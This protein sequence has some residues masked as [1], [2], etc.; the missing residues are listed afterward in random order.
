VNDAA[1]T[2]A[3]RV[4]IDDLGVDYLDPVRRG[5]EHVE[6]FTRFPA[7]SRV[8][9]KPNLTYPIY[10]PGVM[11]SIECLSAVV[12]LLVDRG[13]R[14]TIG[15]ADSGGYNRFSMDEVFDATGI[16]TLAT[17]QGVEILNLSFTEPVVF[18]VRCGLRRLR[19]P[20]PR[21]LLEGFDAFV[22]LPVPKIHMNTLVSLSIKN[23]W[24]CI[25]DP[26]QR[27]RLHPYFSRVIFEVCSRLPPAFAIVDG[28]WGLDRSGPLLGDPVRLDWLMVSDDL[29]A[30]DRTVCRLMG[31]EE[32]K[33]SHL[34]SF[35][36]RGWWG[37]LGAVRVNR[38]LAP[39]ARGTFHLRR[40]WTD[41][42]GLACF[43]SAALAWVGYHSPIAGLLHRLLY[44]FRNPFYD[45]EYESRK[46]AQKRSDD[47]GAQN[48]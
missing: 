20:V 47:S 17:E 38:D 44:V 22:S 45:Y 24:G 15:E 13:Y 21:V 41:L 36:E 31:I 33:V 5:L 1:R 2:W 25:Q 8:F 34:R 43:N 11:T 19:V 27:L 30:T 32:R 37:P 10:R 29:V 46:V 48:G 18:E 23:E 9:L 28:R 12:R 16:R 3:P 40:A 26:A 35:R 39:F 14:V 7:P 6:F 4:F 42:P